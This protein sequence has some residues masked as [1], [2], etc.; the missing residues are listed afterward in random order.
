M[1]CLQQLEQASIISGL[2]G[3]QRAVSSNLL[4][5]HLWMCVY[6]WK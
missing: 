4:G 6:G 1:K 2:C 3:F 5:W